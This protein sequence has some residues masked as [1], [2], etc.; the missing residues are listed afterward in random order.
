MSSIPSSFKRSKHN[1]PP[2]QNI[3]PSLDGATY[4]AE[5]GSVHFAEQISEHEIEGEDDVIDLQPDRKRIK[6]TENMGHRSARGATQRATR[7]VTENM[8]HRSERGAIGRQVSTRTEP[9]ID[10][11]VHETE[12]EEHEDD[13]DVHEREPL[14][15]VNV[16][17]GQPESNR[18]IDS[19]ILRA[20]KGGSDST[21]THLAHT[22]P[23]ADNGTTSHTSVSQ[24][25][26]VTGQ[27]GRS[28]HNMRVV[29]GT[30]AGRLSIVGRPSNPFTQSLYSS[31]QKPSNTRRPSNPPAK[32]QGHQQKAPPARGGNQMA[33]NTSDAP[34]QTS[35][36]HPAPTKGPMLSNSLKA[37]VL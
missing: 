26:Q 23:A 24:T 30:P 35:S 19:K 31:S 1:I 36:T 4:F 17:F 9:H 7:G 11:T 27:N 32:T 5:N 15:D 8:S 34:K 13:V 16:S 21:H 28:N 25:N 29:R 3:P 2:S 14:S 33:G 10:D 6:S 12:V 20:L 18:N 37:K 22:Y